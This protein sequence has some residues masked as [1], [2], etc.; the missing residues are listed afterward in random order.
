[1]S[2]AR[3]HIT[4]RYNSGNPKI[5]RC[6]ICNKDGFRCMGW[7]RES[8]YDNDIGIDEH[9]VIEHKDKCFKCDCCD[10]LF[11]SKC[12]LKK[13]IDSRIGSCYEI[14]IDEIEPEDRNYVKDLNE[15]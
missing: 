8:P 5:Y 3:Y 11:I 12:I 14:T 9:F 1:M 4:D 10:K 15:C 6:N 7:D 13:H 2:K